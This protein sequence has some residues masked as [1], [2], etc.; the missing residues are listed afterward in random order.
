MERCETSENQE[1]RGCPESPCTRKAGA[2]DFL[3]SYKFTVKRK[4]A[5]VGWLLSCMGIDA[6]LVLVVT[7]WG[8]VEGIMILGGKINTDAQGNRLRR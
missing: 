4:Q 5:I 2:G 8:M 1:I 7:I 3:K 6:L